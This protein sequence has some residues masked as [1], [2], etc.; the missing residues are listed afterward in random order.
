[1]CYSSLAP[2]SPPSPPP[3]PPPLSQAAHIAAGDAFEKGIGTTLR[4]AWG[5]VEAVQTTDLPALATHVADVLDFA[6]LHPEIALHPYVKAGDLHQRQE[7]VVFV[8]LA[9]V[10]RALVHID[11]GRL[12]PELR[13]RKVFSLAA[14]V[15]LLLHEASD[16]SSSAAGASAAAYLKPHVLGALEALALL[17]DTE[18]FATYTRQ[19]VDMVSA[20]C[21]DVQNLLRLQTIVQ[22]DFQGDA[23]TRA[24][25]RPLLDTIGRVKRQ[26]GRK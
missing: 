8:Y 1:M 20:D 15:A 4:N 6:G 26:A 16:E 12:M 23:G 7:V 22:K 14:K 24:K 18:D 2:P 17:C 10:T 19:H 11:E 21:E 25:L 5:H 3:P 13:D 9:G